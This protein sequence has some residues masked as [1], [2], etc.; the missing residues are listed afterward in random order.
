MS[1]KNIAAIF[2]L[3]PPAIFTKSKNK[4]APCT[5]PDLLVGL[6]LEIENTRNPEWYMDQLGATAAWSATNDG[7]LRPPG[8]SCEFI[9][10]PMPLALAISETEALLKQYGF[11]DNNYSDRCS[12]HV[13]TNVQDFTQQ[14]LATLSL[15]YTVLEDPLFQFV[16]RYNVKDKNG[17]S[18]DTNLY[19]IP[20][21]QCRM[22]HKL[23]DRIFIDPSGAFH[24]W[25][26]YTA[27]NLLPVVTKGT[28]EWRHMHGTADMQKLTIWLNV[29][30]SIMR[31]AKNSNFDDVVKL[32]KVLN[33][34]SAYQQFFTAVL[35]T[36]LPYDNAYQA[37]LSD[38][39]ISAKYTLMDFE[40]RRT[41][42]KKV[43]KPEEFITLDDIHGDDDRD[44]DEEEERDDRP[45]V[46]VERVLAG[47]A[48]TQAAGA[49]P[50]GFDAAVELR[51]LRE[52]Q[53]MQM[54]QAATAFVH[55]NIAA[56]LWNQPPPPPAE[57]AAAPAQLFRTVNIP[58][59][60]RF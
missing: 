39:I 7:S 21:T 5:N 2:G 50:E 27:L 32:I 56:D 25:Q 40:A 44:E 1:T 51:R 45:P 17:A 29:I 26:K 43:A 10:K 55:P 54:M 6:E 11:N 13:H 33:D 53:R 3:R 31:Y 16:N 36:A 30:G 38:G 57:G 20:W 19:C 59:R 14:Q 41:G 48:G 23:V 8:G 15:V 4:P 9:S 35:G 34:T 60:G 46:R 49:V 22:N 47:Q 12:V 24:R 18:R 28:V 42:K 37:A 58:G 52:Q